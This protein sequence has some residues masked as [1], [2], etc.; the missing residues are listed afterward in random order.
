MDDIHILRQIT[1]KAYEYNTQTDILSIDC[2]HAFDSIQTQN[3]K[4]ITTVRNIQ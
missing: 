2:K 4:N 1:E 3:D